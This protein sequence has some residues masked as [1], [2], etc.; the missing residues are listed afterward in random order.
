MGSRPSPSAAA[1]VAG[2]GATATATPAWGVRVTV[3]R[4]AFDGAGGASQSRA[5]LAELLGTPWPHRLRLDDFVANGVTHE[6]GGRRQVELA[7]DRGAM[8]LHRLET[9]VEDIGDLLVG[10]TFGDQLHHTPL[11]IG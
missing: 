8:R 1:D 11:A 10:V 5:R 7:H 9:D 2:D 3:S 6:T 4:C